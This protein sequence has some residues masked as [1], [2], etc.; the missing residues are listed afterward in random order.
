MLFFCLICNQFWW[1]KTYYSF[2]S[3]ITRGM[4]RQFFSK[5]F[6]WDK[7]SVEYWS[8][9]LIS[10]SDI[11]SKKIFIRN[12]QEF[13]WIKHVFFTPID[14][15][16]F[17]V[18]FPFLWNW[19]NFAVINAVYRICWFTVRNCR[20]HDYWSVSSIIIRKQKKTFIRPSMVTHLQNIKKA[21][22]IRSSNIVWF[23]KRILPWNE[24]K[25]QSY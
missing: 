6:N 25:K 21:I 1:I 16:V 18:F 17:P 2:Q 22:T 4:D 7:L 9:P 10:S 13:S 24:K 12:I 20:S 5:D 8:E 15:S 11:F 23:T 14:S 19:T 3:K